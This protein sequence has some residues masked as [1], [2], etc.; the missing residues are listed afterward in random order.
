MNL[1]KKITWFCWLFVLQGTVLMAQGDGQDAR[2][3]D[4]KI[5]DLL[6]RFP[7]Q[8]AAS[9]AVL[10][11]N[12]ASLGQEGLLKMATMLSPN[13]NNEKLTYALAGFAFYASHPS[14]SDYART[15]VQAYGKA[16]D[17]LEYPEG[18]D[19]LLAQFKWIGK[20]DAAPFVEPFLHDEHHSARASQVLENIGSSS[21][22]QALLLALR[23]SSNDEHKVNFIQAL[24]GIGSSLALAD[25][26]PYAQSANEDLRKVALYALGEIADP[27]SAKILTRAAKDAG[28]SNESTN[29]TGTYLRY[30]SRLAD[31]GHTKTA[32]K[33]AKGL[34]KMAAVG[35]QPH[36]QAGALALLARLEPAKAPN[37]LAAAALSDNAQYRGAALKYALSSGL[38]SNLSIWR[39]LLN[40]ASP[41]AKVAL[42]D[43]LA[44]VKGQE[45]LALL[46]P[47]LSSAE[48]KVR[49]A[50]IEASVS[51][52]GSAA[53]S[54]LL[55]Q[56]ANADEAT[57]SRIQT[58]L[59]TMPGSGVSAEVA[60]AISG[61][62]ASVKMM[63]IEVLAARSAEEYM[64]VVLEQVTDS[65]ESVQV[66]AYGALSSLANGSHAGQLLDLLKSSRQE[67]QLQ[68]VQKALVT[69]VLRMNNQRSQTGW[70]AQHLAGLESA[71]QPYLYEILG[72]TG[73]EAAMTQLESIYESGN[74]DQKL[75]VIQALANSKDSKAPSMLLAIA[76]S[77]SGGL[78]EAA[79][80]GYVQLIPSQSWTAENK[81]IHLRN[82][83]ELTL[84]DQVRSV[85]IKALGQF[86]TFQALVT[87]GSYLD[88][89]ALQ[90]D[91]ARAVMSIVSNTD[92]F[93]GEVVRGL[94]EK[95]RDVISGQDSQYY[96]TSLQKFLDEM[97]SGR[98]FYTL[99]NGVDLDGWQGVFSN[100]IKRGQM[101]QR[102]YDREQA[103][104][105]QVMHE[106]WEAK[107]GLL[108]FK[109]KGENIGTV[110]HYGDFEMF[111]DWKITADGD[112]G[113]YLRG[114]PQ[115]QIWDIARTNVGAE[116]G[117]GGLYNNT[118][119]ESKPTK[120]ADNPVEEWNTFHVKMVG[121][122][123]TVYLNGEL[124]VDEVV[125][126]NYWDRSQPIFPS[127]MIE[128]QAHGTYVAYRDLY[129]K[130][131]DASVPFEMSEE[132]SMAGFEVL[133]DGTDLNKWTGN[134]IDYVVENGHIAIYPDR[135]GS[136]NLFTEKEYGDFEFRF[137]FK[138]TPGANNGLGI[139]AP[140]TGDA[141]YAGMELQILD[142]TADIY[143]NLKEYQ[144]HGSL[145]GVA[146]AKRGALKP[147]GEWNYQEVIVKGNK[148]KVILNGE[149]ILDTDISVAKE[150]G[151]LDGREHPGLFR[152]KGHIGFL[153]HGDVVYFR[154]IRILDMGK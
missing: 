134:K 90:Q 18:R 25:I 115:V 117:S 63:L 91:A 35:N 137:E 87:A 94:V 114:T 32:S 23:T 149:T 28:G 124:V 121:E 99:F 48:P 141:A 106:G 73:G 29:A 38:A 55:A 103:K 79:L 102:T 85:S 74:A 20:E 33:L 119:N 5:A 111:V 11:E 31:T 16:L 43:M 14:K 81:V 58:A 78:K 101:D 70:V 112:A 71:K 93:Y 10:M 128:L 30:I 3:L 131:L 143:K 126:E 46:I 77:G 36:V 41:E 67:W 1:F 138:L 26:N 95:T 83:L 109:G 2:T 148:I 104:A 47:L 57:L 129:I 34:H 82:A 97:P 140:L 27:K 146:A 39:P 151:T 144:F 105:N 66:S 52:G 8:D 9:Q 96:K 62:D 118:K 49:A 80:K 133:F 4:T 42:I 21:S 7:A 123:V 60:K 50:A 37:L 142:N 116:V 132:E 100:P 19:F 98:G 68:A 89:P 135:G 92:Q 125:L 88:M 44:R 61:S 108:V 12:M 24:G 120:V 107:D 150:K 130:E 54:D 84:D 139:R 69:S 22:E 65:N 122:K 72:Q 147:V 53:L 13:T 6:N 145:Y 51:V 59:K 64:G 17:K 152:D 136:G 153:G 40:Q 127:E 154:N 56:T 86:P 45:T 76:R 15:A 110:K 113:I 75:A